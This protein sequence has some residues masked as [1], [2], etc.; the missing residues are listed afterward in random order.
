MA[1]ELTSRA[2]LSRRDVHTAAESD[3]EV[4]IVPADA[5]AIAVGFPGRPASA[6]VF[7][8]EGNVLVNVVADGLGRSEPQPQL[9]GTHRSAKRC[10]PECGC[11]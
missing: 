2:R 4:S 6:R 9:V 11:N 3:C 7:I 8:P 10:R 1:D 5:R